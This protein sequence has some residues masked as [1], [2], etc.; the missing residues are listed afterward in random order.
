M[1]LLCKLGLHSFEHVK[2]VKQLPKMQV[3]VYS[4][5]RRCYATKIAT[6]NMYGKVVS[7]SIIQFQS[8][9]E[10]EKQK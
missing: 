5:C 7:S 9:K 2:D 6:Y 3:D 4:N 10:Q 1:N 8:S